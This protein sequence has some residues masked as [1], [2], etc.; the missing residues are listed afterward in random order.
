MSGQTTLRQ[1]V[2]NFLEYRGQLHFSN[3]DEA[4]I[5]RQFASFAD[6]YAPGAPVSEKLILQWAA[7][8]KPKNSRRDLYELRNFIPWLALRDDRVIAPRLE[9]LRC[10]RHPRTAPYIYAPEE[11][12]ALFAALWTTDSVRWGEWPR[13][14]HAAAL[15]LLE[16]TGIRVGEAANLDDDDVDLSSGNLHIR[17]SK[18]L[19]LR[20]VPLHETAVAALHRYRKQRQK[21]CPRPKSRAFLLSLTGRRLNTLPMQV[22]FRKVRKSACVPFRPHRREPRLYDFRHAFASRHL[23][24]AYRENRDID[25]EVADLSVYMGH[26]RIANTYWYLTALPELRALCAERFRRYAEAIRRGDRS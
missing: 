25:V 26:Q 18:N 14:S 11:V 9:L 23:L 20:L 13:A 5:L 22:F 21:Y 3:K 6:E 16:S 1:M 2:K 24:R 10:S 12:E 8:S 7:A 15:G 19:P 17:K 4:R